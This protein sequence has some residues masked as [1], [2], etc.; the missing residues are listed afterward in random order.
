MRQISHFHPSI[1]SKLQEFKFVLASSSPRRLS[2]VKD[3]L[4]LHNVLVIPS[5]FEENLLKSE[6]TVQEYVRKTS[7]MKAEFVSRDLREQNR[8]E[9]YIVL[10]ADTIIACNNKIFEKPLNKAKQREAF[11]QY[12]EHPKIQVI[13]SI[14][15]TK[16]DEGRI[17]VK[18]DFEITNLVFD[19]DLSQDVI[20]AYIDCEE[21][22]NVAGGFKFQNIGSLLFKS[23]EG[24]Y[25]NVV[26]LPVRRTF[27]MLESLLK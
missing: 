24:D 5:N 26:G 9:K 22:L 14:V 20:D 8:N 4:G 11:N 2:I 16:I 12:K 10:S 7:L 25:F 21:G 27:H 1:Y 6:N 17:T 13:T 15:L 19:S 23:I 18:Q 3:N